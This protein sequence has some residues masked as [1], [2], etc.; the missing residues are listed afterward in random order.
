MI[1]AENSPNFE[2]GM[3]LDGWQITEAIQAYADWGHGDI[4]PIQLVYANDQ[5]A[6]DY[7]D[8][9]LGGADRIKFTKSVLIAFKG[10]AA[11]ILNAYDFVADGVEFARKLKG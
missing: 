7:F 10:P 9:Y 6:K 4:L 8:N 1:I 5:A 11:I 3:T 2:P